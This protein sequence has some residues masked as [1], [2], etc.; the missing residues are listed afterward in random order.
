MIKSIK[1]LIRIKSS[2][3]L[4]KKLHLV[5]QGEMVKTFKTRIQI[6]RIKHRM[7]EA[8]I[9]IKNEFWFTLRFETSTNSV[10]KGK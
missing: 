7:D 6:F 1:K 4:I 8:G 9:K 2:A 10:S 5:R 3:F